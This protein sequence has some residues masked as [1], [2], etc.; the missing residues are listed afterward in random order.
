MKLEY[1]DIILFKP[2]GLIGKLIT[3]IDGCPYSHGAI[4]L[5]YEKGVPLFIESHESKRGV[6][7]SK[8]EEWN[9]YIVL[10]PLK[11]HYFYPQEYKDTIN[12]LGR[13]YDYGRLLMILKSK[14]DKF[15]IA[16]NDPYK[17]ICTEL[18][19]NVYGYKLG[20]GDIC[21]PKTIYS[22]FENGTLIRI[23]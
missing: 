18:C 6:V 2:T 16:N 11:S 7:I 1:G 17:L 3:K 21:T 19:D 22:L 5:K 13:K 4:F 10:R 15:N 20:E 23:K 14:F 8:L 12:L 9:N